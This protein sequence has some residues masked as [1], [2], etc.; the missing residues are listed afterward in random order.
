MNF[1]Q[2]KINLYKK[3][4]WHCWVKHFYK[5]W[6]GKSDTIGQY[7]FGE[8]CDICAICGVKSEFTIVIDFGPIET[9][10]RDRLNSS[11]PIRSCREELVKSVLEL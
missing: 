7:I 3:L 4:G 6:N 2:I 9:K 1:L 5:P 8:D 11:D 10:H